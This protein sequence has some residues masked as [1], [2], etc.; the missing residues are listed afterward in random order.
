MK[1]PPGLDLNWVLL[2]IPADEDEGSEPEPAVRFDAWGTGEG[3]LSLPP[4][5]LLAFRL[6]PGDL[7]ALE[8]DAAEAWLETY[9]GALA[10][11]GP[12]VSPAI[13]WGFLARFLSRP[14][15]AVEPDGTIA[16]PAALFPLRHGER[17]ELKIEWWGYQRLYLRRAR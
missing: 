16:L 4:E 10:E 12:T 15:T 7:L 3:K 13:R 8:G 17:V 11:G 6:A 2:G 14:L 1:R 5:V 9:H